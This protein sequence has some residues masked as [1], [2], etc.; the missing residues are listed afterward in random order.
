[1]QQPQVPTRAPAH[2]RPRLGAI[3]D[4]SSWMTPASSGR[5][6]GACFLSHLLLSG[7]CLVATVVSVCVLLEK[8]TQA[9]VLHGVPG[10]VE[11]TE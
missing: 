5:F 10:S 11:A 4:G 3:S 7:M 6:L 9:F 1:M 8:H 2:H